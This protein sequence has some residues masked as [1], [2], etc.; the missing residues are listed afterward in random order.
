M[1]RVRAR[2]AQA[3]RGI[4]LT[5][6]E[7]LEARHGHQIPGQPTQIGSADERAAA[8]AAVAEIDR[9]Q[10]RL[11]RIYRA[12]ATSGSR[13]ADDWLEWAC[14]RLRLAR[15]YDARMSARYPDGPDGN[16]EHR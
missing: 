8:V 11:S 12:M 1:T 10:F 15:D 2:R 6:D 3:L 13:P 9:R 7:E 14:G 16:Y 4:D 5:I